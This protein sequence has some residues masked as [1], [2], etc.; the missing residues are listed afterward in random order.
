MSAIDFRDSIVQNGRMQFTVANLDLAIVNAM[1]RVI[2]SD[3]KN[4]S[5]FFHPYDPSQNHVTISKNTSALHDEMIGHRVSLIPVCLT[6]NEIAEVQNNPAKFR[7]VLDMKNSTPQTQ[8]VTTDDFIV[9]EN[10]SIVSNEKKRRIFPADMISK[11]YILLLR[12]RPSPLNIKQGEEISLEA[13]L[14][15]G[16]AKRHACFCPVSVCFFTNVVDEKAAAEA[17]ESKLKSINEERAASQMAPL[18]DS[19]VESIRQ[20]FQCLESKRHFVKNEGGEPTM[21]T[22]YLESE[23]RMRPQ[24]IVMKAFMVL[25]DKLAVLKTALETGNQDDVKLL[26]Y[27][28]IPGLFQV[29]MLLEGHTLGNLI[30]SMMYNKYIRDAKVSG[31]DGAGKLEFVGYHQPHPS[32]DYVFLKIKLATATLADASNPASTEAKARVLLIDAFGWIADVMAALAVKWYQTMKCQTLQVNDLDDFVAKHE[33]ST[34][35]ID[36]T[37]ATSGRAPAAVAA[38]VDSVDETAPRTAPAPAPGPAKTKKAPKKA[39]KTT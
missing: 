38:V 31:G 5:M 9:Y 16:T 25:H 19:E 6:E 3:I 1:R 28:N 10:G 26:P 27:G 20:D 11:D 12:L 29:N 35:R 34:R 37:H 23:C 22:F 8:N 30:Q 15:I 32:E 14:D 17:L 18:T 33:E 24:Y 39:A 13:T 36:L 7:F 2:L 4:V 21:F